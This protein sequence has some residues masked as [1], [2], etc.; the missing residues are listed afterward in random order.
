MKLVEYTVCQD[1]T[2]HSISTSFVGT[3]E[4]T[5]TIAIVNDLDYPFIDTSLGT[6]YP[7]DTK[8]ARLGDTILIPLEIEGSDVIDNISEND[9]YGIDLLL[10]TN[11]TDLSMIQIGEFKENQGDLKT[12]Q[13]R[14]T[15]IQDLTHRLMTEKGS[16]LLHPDYG[17]D[18]LKIIGEKTYIGWEQKVIIE[19]MKT[20]M[21]DP[22]VE[23]VQDVTFEKFDTGIHVKCILITP[24]GLVDFSEY[25]GGVAQ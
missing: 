17:S 23:N 15:L 18:L 12:T 11:K 22:R 25:V 3:V 5:N 1:D 4:L 10:T 8:V 14:D 19:I 9:S 13:G 16:L 24:L 20:M 7:P 2:L 6:V 21:S